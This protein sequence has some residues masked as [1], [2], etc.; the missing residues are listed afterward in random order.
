MGNRDKC[1]YTILEVLIFIAVSSLM[2]VI[3]IT[4][5]GGRQQQ[6]QFS[7]STR[8]V[9]AKLR[10]IINDVTT[11]YYPTNSTVSCEVIAGEV[12]IVASTNQEIGTNSNCIYIGKALQFS[13]D[14]KSDVIRIYNL[15]GKRYADNSQ[16]PTLSINDAQP[17]AVALP[18]D[19]NF[20]RSYEDYPIPYGLEIT[21]VIVPISASINKLYGVIAIVNNF[22]DTT[23]SDGQTVQVGGI[24]GTSLGDSE[25]TAVDLIN[26]LTE[27]SLFDPPQNGF[28]D[29]SETEG[30]TICLKSPD[31]KQASITL[32]KNGSG[33]TE[34]LL[35]KYVKGC[36]I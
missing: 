20:E 16:N 14:G 2:F 36:D 22:G 29:K 7:Q 15:A 23:V 25:S 5:I 18:D 30:L 28:F 21:K 34:L 9:D 31:Y 26:Q 35:D 6:V 11:G 4:A 13:P 27:T 12:Q 19:S 10:D 3:A 32:G 24:V 17:K 33:T 8:E 1:G